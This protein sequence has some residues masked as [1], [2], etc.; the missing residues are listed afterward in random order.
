MNAHLN[1]FKTYTKK[2]RNHQL[3]NDLTRALAICLQEDPLFFH[4]FLKFIFGNS[5]Y[6]T[7]FFDDINNS[8][9]ISIEIQKNSSDIKEFEHVFAVSLSEH[10]MTYD[11]FWNQSRH[12][13]YD[14]IC[15]IVLRINNVV[16]IIETKR[17]AVDC[18][19]Q[20]YNQIFNV[21]NHNE[22]T[23][24]KQDNLVTP[25][26]LN[27]LKLMD[28]AVKVLSFERSIGSP[29]RFLSDFV[30][31]VKLHNYKWLPE[32][33]LLSVSPTDQNAISRR[34]DSVLSE[35]EKTE[36]YQK[37]EIRDRVGL[38]LNQPWAEEVIY[39][40]YKD[41]S[42]VVAVYP[43]NTKAQGRS[44]F[45]KDPQFKEEFTINGKNYPLR[46]MYHVKFNGQRYITGLWFGE[47]CLVE[48][49]TLYSKNTF[50]N[51][52]GRKKRSDWQ[53]VE[54]LFDDNFIVEKFNWRYHC[55]WDGKLIQSNR[56]QFDLSFGYELAVHI[57]FE[58]LKQIDTN[59]NDL[60]G[61]TEVVKT[62]Y[63][64]FTNVI[65]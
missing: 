49:S 36:D 30:N 53:K 57:P 10:E 7:E 18:T 42:L 22:I 60:T 25:F 46:K 55:D 27:W 56:N 34:F 47:D 61:L 39:R 26:D 64:Q 19:A 45:H 12:T 24:S 59:K 21:F 1:V 52:A 58:D 6:F 29:N 35:L 17:D 8:N 5:N 32:P 20:L 2:E 44:I 41:G 3:E 54:K 65:I 37:F 16:I 63:D 48:D 23:L 38:K 31:L 40:V 43:G 14:P 28:I 11:H 9:D 13:K 50:N 15:D 51:F 33:A 4:E 62:I